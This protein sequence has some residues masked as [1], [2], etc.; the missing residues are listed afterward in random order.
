MIVHFFTKGDSNVPSSRQRA[1]LLAQE[2][3]KYHVETIVHEPPIELISKTKW[4]E[5]L[6]LIY[7]VFLAIFKI[8]KGEI[9]FLQRAIYN[10][11]FIILIIFHKLFF[12]RKIIFDFDDAIYLHSPSKTKLFTKIADVVTVGSH[13]LFDWAKKYNKNTFLIPT[14]TYF[15]NFPQKNFSSNKKEKLILGWVGN[16]SA[17]KDNLN[18]LIPI[19]NSLV[20]RKVPVQMV[21]IGMNKNKEITDNFLQIKNLDIKIIDWLDPKKIIEAI[22]DFDVGLMPLVDSPWNRGKCALKIIEYMACGVATVASPVGE[23]NYVIKDGVN[24]FLPTNTE[25]WVAVIENLYNNPSLLETVGKKGRQTIEKT[26]N[27]DMQIIN[28]LSIIGK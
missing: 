25:E 22:Y 10:K 2:L 16:A 4:P 1:H 9:I 5:K 20:A 27:Y 26:Y 6:K 7:K 12:R 14:C 15:A 8:K 18:L 24:G 21:I 13:E 28:I 3:Q 11:Y 19:L 23:N 17:H